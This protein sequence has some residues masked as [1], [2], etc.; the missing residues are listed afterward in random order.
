MPAFE[1]SNVLAIDVDLAEVRAAGTQD[2][3]QHNC[4]T[5]HRGGRRQRVWRFA[6][7][8][9]WTE[10]RVDGDRIA[11]DASLARQWTLAGRG[12]TLKSALDVQQDEAAGALMRLRRARPE[13]RV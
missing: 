3:L 13:S 8:G 6:R 4:L 10:V 12:I 11:D 1:R 9:K 2:L 5:F 7:H